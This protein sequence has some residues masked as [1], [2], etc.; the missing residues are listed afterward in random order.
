M[1]M[2]LQIGM[3][4]EQSLERV[5]AS[6]NRFIPRYRS[7]TELNRLVA[8]F[9]AI[10]LTQHPEIE[11]YAPP[12]RQFKQKSTLKRSTSAPATQLSTPKRARALSSLPVDVSPMRRSDSAPPTISARVHG[13]SHAAAARAPS[14]EYKEVRIGAGVDT[15]STWV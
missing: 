6:V 7:M 12:D 1:A 4:A 13:I 15:S 14:P 11:N 5:H 9:R 8:L 10:T 2:R 3:M